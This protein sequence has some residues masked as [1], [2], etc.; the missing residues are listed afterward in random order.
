[1]RVRLFLICVV[2]LLVAQ[3]GFARGIKEERETLGYD[4][5]SE[6]VNVYIEAGDYSN[7]IP[8]LKR[9]HVLN[10]QALN[11]VE[12]LGILYSVIPEERPEMT[13]AL[14]WLL[15]A[16]ERHS[17]YNLVYYNLACIYSIKNDLENAEK[18][19]NKA[20]IFGYSNFEWM[21][22]DDDLVNFRTTSW[23]KGIEDKYGQ[24]E[25]QL[26]KFF[27]YANT[28]NNT[29]FEEN[30]NFYSEIISSF[31]ELAP[32]IPVFKWYPLWLS[33]SLYRLSATNAPAAECYLEIKEIF[34]EMEFPQFRG[35]AIKPLYLLMLLV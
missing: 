9:M 11:I 10:P 14:Y 32:D 7:A 19:M 20:I 33:A 27:E 21:S 4:E 34:D 25:M 2:L 28:D 6:Q 22:K 18:A 12:Y 31:N 1:M 13:N 35:H 29:S 3:A 5:L 24:I 8:L 30:L 16:E 26:V 23:W 17:T 15:E